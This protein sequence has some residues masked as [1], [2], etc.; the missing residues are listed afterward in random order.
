MKIMRLIVCLG[1]LFSAVQARTVVDEVVAVIYHKSGV[2]VIAASDIKPTLEG[3][4]RTLRDCVLQMLMVLDADDM[5][6]TVTSEEAERFLGELQKNNNISREGMVSLFE[7][8]GYTFEEGLEELRCRQMVEQ[9][10]DFRV[11]SNKKFLVQRAEVVAEYES[12]PQTTEAVYTLEQVS[13]PPETPIDKEFS[14]AELDA[15]SWDEP[16]EITESEL[17]DERKSIAQATVGSIVDRDL[18]NE[19]LELTR[20]VAKKPAQKVEL[21]AVYDT[22]MRKLQAER[23]AGLMAEYQASLLEKAVIRFTHPEDKALVMEAPRS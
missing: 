6:V 14:Q 7:G 20:L 23:F 5:H 19:G 10:V 1:I 11:R 2:I 18:T 3:R 21:D 12:N 9:I 17:V 4:P 15:L 16:F 22:V 13:L 8:L